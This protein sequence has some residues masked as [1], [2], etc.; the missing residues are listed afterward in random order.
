MEE[1]LTDLCK[2]VGVLGAFVN[3]DK[4]ELIR[5]QMPPGYTNEGLSEV[6]CAAIQGF[7][8]VELSG[9][10][11]S[12]IEWEYD[13]YFLIVKRLKKGIISVLCTK[14][15][16]IPLLKISFNLVAKKVE[17]KMNTKSVKQD[18]P[19]GSTVDEVF[20]SMLETSLAKK[21]GP[22]AKVLINEKV[23]K[24]G[25]DRQKFLDSRWGELIEQLSAEIDNPVEKEEFIKAMNEIITQ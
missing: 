15:I 13:D 20:F 6:G 10:K 25:E 2:V 7:Q 5:Q 3:N 11:I 21:I 16:S 8:G 12:E 22:I 1:A 14:S 23:T 19:P 18:R 4:G 17:E 9:H 24:M